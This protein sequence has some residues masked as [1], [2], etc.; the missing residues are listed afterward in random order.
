MSSFNTRA[1]QLYERLGY[2]RI[3]VL[4]DYL[5]RGYDEIFMRKTRM[6]IK[7]FFEGR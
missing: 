4:R 5:V 2:E 6:P 7:E 1:Q 3:G